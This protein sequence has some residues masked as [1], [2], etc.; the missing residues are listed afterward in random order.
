MENLKQREKIN[1]PS[2]AFLRFLLISFTLSFLP[3]GALRRYRFQL[4]SFEIFLSLFFH[5]R[6]DDE[7]SLA[8]KKTYT[9]N[10]F[11][12]Q[13]YYCDVSGIENAFRAFGSSIT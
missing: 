8:H 10:E 3:T 9:R 2:Q 5:A 12:I 1:L 6:N 4:F 11:M 13:F 7:C